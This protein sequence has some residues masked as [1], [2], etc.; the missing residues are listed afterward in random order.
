MGAGAGGGGWGWGRSSRVKGGQSPGLQ[1]SSCPFRSPS[2]SLSLKGGLGCRGR[3][4]FSLS[5]EVWSIRMF[6]ERA[7]LTNGDAGT[8]PRLPPLGRDFMRA[9][10]MNLSMAA[11]GR[12]VMSLLPPCSSPNTVSPPKGRPSTATCG[13]PSAASPR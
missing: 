5:G 4:A 7:G 2:A 11:W 6:E 8:E 3:D 1:L 10:Q 12:L 13:T 9:S